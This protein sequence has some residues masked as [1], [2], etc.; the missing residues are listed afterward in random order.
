[1]RRVRG[2]QRGRPAQ[3]KS[4]DAARCDERGQ[5]RSSARRRAGIISCSRCCCWCSPDAP[6]A[7]PSSASGSLGSLAAACCAALERRRGSSSV[8]T[9]R[10]GRAGRRT[11][12]RSARCE[13]A[14][15]CCRA[16]TASRRRSY[17]PRSTIC[18]HAP[19]TVRCR[20]QRAQAIT[21]T[22][23]ALT[24]AAAAALA[25]CNKENHTIVAGG[26]SGDDDNN[27]TANANVQLPPAIVAG[28]DLSL[29]RQQG[30]LR[31]LAVGQQVGEHPHRARTATPTQVTAAEAGKPMT[32]AGGY[33]VEGTRRRLERED[34]GP[35]P[36][37]ADLQR[38]SRDLTIAL[39]PLNWP[40]AAG[41]I[42]MLISRR[43]FTGGAISASRSAQSARPPA[44]RPGSRRP[45]PPRSPRSAPMAR[46]ISS[47]SACPE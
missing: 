42:P 38:L 5:C 4:Q 23:S 6:G 29:R 19:L 11:R 30:G 36:P 33:S 34:R 9:S 43:A 10:A 45:S 12:D 21:R 39:R 44:S 27:V 8:M 3:R 15:R 37:G 46:R 40:Q 18:K 2:A 35:G 7:T 16:G 41:E 24:L 47:I 31:R 26:G 14:A 25:G 17:V 20:P 13:C 22:P 28:E 1:M 32:A